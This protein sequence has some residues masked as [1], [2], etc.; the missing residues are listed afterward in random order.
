M[1][2]CDKVICYTRGKVVV[3]GYSCYDQ[4]VLPVQINTKFTTVEQDNL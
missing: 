1:N 4:N 3:R 2:I